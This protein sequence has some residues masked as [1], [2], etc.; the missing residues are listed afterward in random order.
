VTVAAD[1]SVYFVDKGND[2]LRKV[3]TSG[4]ITTVAGTTGGY[5][6]DS[7]PAQSAQLA[8][9]FDV[10]LGANGHLYI[11]D[12]ENH[13]IRVIDSAG[14]IT[15][16]GGTGTPGGEGDGGP[17]VDA[18]LHHPISVAVDGAG[19]VYLADENNHRVRRIDDTCGNGQVDEES[20]AT[21]PRTGPR[22]PVRAAS[23]AASSVRP[24]RSVDP[25]STSATS[26][27]RAPASSAVCPEDE[28]EPDSD[29]DAFCDPIDVCPNDFDPEQLDRDDDGPG[30]AC[31]PCTNLFGI[32][33]DRPRALVTRLNKAPGAQKLVLRGRFLPFPATPPIDPLA[34]GIRVLVED[35]TGVRID[36]SI[37]GGA[38]DGDLSAGWRI[39]DL[40]DG[41]AATYS[42]AGTKIPLVGG[43]K[44]SSSR[45][46][47][48]GIESSSSPPFR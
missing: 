32:V 9:P 43:I 17:A 12:A 34:V 20:P 35:E 4:V 37:P 27:M 48:R 21:W 44:R 25:R 16:L 23:Q 45:S 10:A 19:H 5:G 8:M 18:L 30:D 28:V 46:T 1:G 22:I 40:D 24:A 3:D 33:A 41:F 47:A 7:G 2:R 38:Y 29:G 31:D 15:T 13:R 36:A 6:G 39:R 42:N 14:V 11:A 26:P